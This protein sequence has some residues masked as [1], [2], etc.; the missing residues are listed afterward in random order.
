MF[1]CVPLEDPLAS[2]ILCMTIEH[3]NPTSS[4]QRLDNILT[5]SLDYDTPDPKNPNHKVSAAQLSVIV[6]ELTV[7]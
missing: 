4:I 7:G 6:R 5:M 2:S 1:A 3:R